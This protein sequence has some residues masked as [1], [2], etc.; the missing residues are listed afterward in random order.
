[1]SIAE[2]FIYRTFVIDAEAKRLKKSIPKK[3]KRKKSKK[4]IS[5]RGS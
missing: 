3:P 5:K 2:A 4:A 1:M